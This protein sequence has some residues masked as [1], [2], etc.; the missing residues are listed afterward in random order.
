MNPVTMITEEEDVFY[1]SEVET[2]QI[3]IW[4]HKDGINCEYELLYPVSSHYGGVLTVYDHDA[5]FCFIL[6]SILF[7]IS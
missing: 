3:V 4:T 5:S 2:L 6:H 1:C 7:V